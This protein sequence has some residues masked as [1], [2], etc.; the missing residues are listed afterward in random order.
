[1]SLLN[2]GVGGDR[3]ENILWR[4][5][6][7]NLPRSSPAYVVLLAGTN[8]TD[9]PHITGDAIAQG[10]AAIISELR[11]R[12]PGSRIIVLSILPRGK[13]ASE[14]RRQPIER[15]NQVIRQCADNR[16][17]FYA[18]LWDQFLE[19]DGTIR[20]SLMKGDLLHVGRGYAIL[21]EAIAAIVHRTERQ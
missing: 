5:E 2:I 9:D 13:L 15:A 17:V 7:G 18:D 11:T 8:N 19:P 14:P 20:A 12:L 21:D 1:M 6:N 10:L 3:T 16:S 4:I